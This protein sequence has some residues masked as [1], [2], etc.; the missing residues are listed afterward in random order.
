MCR[1]TDKEYEGK[2]EKLRIRNNKMKLTL[3]GCLTWTQNPNS[4][5]IRLSAL[6]TCVFKAIYCWSKISGVIGL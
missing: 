5:N 3:C 4:F 1:V 2:K 6:I